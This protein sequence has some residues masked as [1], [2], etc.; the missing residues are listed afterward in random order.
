[1][2]SSSGAGGMDVNV[3]GHRLR[4]LAML[5]T[6]VFDEVRMDATATIPALI[7]VGLSTLLMGIGGWLWYELQDYNYSA[8]RFFFK[9]A[10]LGS[11]FAILL[12]FVW[13]AVT[14][15]MLNQVFRAR[16]DM[17]ELVR[18]MG[19]ATF[20]LVLSVLMFI[21]ALDFG[22]ALL[23]IT[24]TFGASQLAVA[25]ATDAQPGQTLAANATGFAVWGIVLTL[26]ANSNTFYDR[27]APGI[28][29]FNPFS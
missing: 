22:I 27:L 24:L 7:I 6:T 21:P 4:R 14:Y 2:Q 20:P 10:I 5:D 16:A 9:S 26:L 12:W 29:I 1:M 19:F 3:Q 8:G 11:I 18:V 23:A 13:V 17:Q 25:S 28:F 15:V